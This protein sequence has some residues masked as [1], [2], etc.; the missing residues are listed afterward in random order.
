MLSAMKLHV[1]VGL[2]ICFAS[3]VAAGPASAQALNNI[4]TRHRA[5]DLTDTAG[6][7]TIEFGFAPGAGADRVLVAIVYHEYNKGEDVRPENVRLHGT[8]GRTIGRATNTACGSKVEE[9]LEGEDS[10]AVVCV[11]STLLLEL[12]KHGLDAVPLAAIGGALW[13][14]AV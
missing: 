12:T 11:N 3:F 8:G 1:W 5:Q 2:L 14:F 7:D 6:N 13:C 9:G 4:L 10:L